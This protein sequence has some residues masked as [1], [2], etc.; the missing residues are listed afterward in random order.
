MKKKASHFAP[1]R[2]DFPAVTWRAD[3]NRY[4]I[5]ARPKGGA[6]HYRADRAD[7]LAL[8]DTLAADFEFKGRSAFSTPDIQTAKLSELGV[9]PQ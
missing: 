7:A 9:T 3:K 1:S 2:L 6:R 8:P 5:D 4:M